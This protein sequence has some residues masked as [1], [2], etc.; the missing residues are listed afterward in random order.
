MIYDE[1][2]AT[3]DLHKYRTRARSGFNDLDYPVAEGAT[4]TRDQS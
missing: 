3:D 4:T 2:M 1:P